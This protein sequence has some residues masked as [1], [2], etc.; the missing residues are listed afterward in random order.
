LL[1]CVNCPP[2]QGRMRRV[3]PEGSCRNFRGRVRRGGRRTGARTQDD[4]VRYLALTQG[5]FAIVDARDYEWLSRHKWSAWRNDRRKHIWM[6]REIMQP[7]DEMVVDHVDGYFTSQIE[8]ARAYDREARRRFGPF[9]WLNFPEELD[10]GSARATGHARPARNHAHA[11]KKKR[12]HLSRV[13]TLRC[14]TH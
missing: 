10:A 2:A 9:A 1:V 4:D 3:L 12:G 5:R 7:S 14:C 13:T 11:P 6:H 8:A